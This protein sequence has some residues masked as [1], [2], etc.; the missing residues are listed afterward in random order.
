MLRLVTIFAALLPAAYATS[1]LAILMQDDN[2][3]TDSRRVRV[4]F[5]GDDDE[6]GAPTYTPCYC[7]AVGSEPKNGPACAT[8][9]ASNGQ[10][11]LAQPT[12]A[13]EMTSSYNSTTGIMTIKNRGGYGASET[14]SITLDGP[15]T[16]YTV[17]LDVEPRDDFLKVQGKDGKDVYLT[18]NYSACLRTRT[19]LETAYMDENLAPGTHYSESFDDYHATEETQNHQ[20]DLCHDI[21]TGKLLMPAPV[22]I[23]GSVALSWSSDADDD[24]GNDS[25][26]HH[27]SSMDFFE[28]FELLMVFNDAY[29][30]DVAVVADAEATHICLGT[31]SVAV[32]DVTDGTESGLPPD[33][34][35][36]KVYFRDEDLNKLKISGTIEIE[37]AAVAMV[38]T[39]KAYSITLEKF[40]PAG[41]WGYILGQLE[42][43]A[44]FSSTE[45]TRDGLPYGE[46]TVKIGGLR[47][48]HV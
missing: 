43:D 27:S 18:G 39:E 28:G 2:W 8:A 31:E 46:Y 17:H 48:V 44:E 26:G 38:N 6:S 5:R 13:G 34:G 4:T 14:Q 3:S 9:V 30:A 41:R 45:R 12:G 29:V 20:D 42:N 24:G 36:A 19:Y 35:P 32:S 1:D 7:D 25:P 47:R 15:G 10:N 40:E 22:E 37:S 16:L 11:K 33:G 23:A 21:L